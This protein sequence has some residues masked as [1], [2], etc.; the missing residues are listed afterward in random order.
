[1]TPVSEKARRAGVA[2][3]IGRSNV[4]KSTLLNALV[5]TKIAIITPKPQTTRMS[6]HGI[7]TR[8]QAQIIF[9]DTPGVLKKTRDALTKKMAE[10]IKDSLDG[11]DVLLYVVDPTRGIGEEQR[12]A[13]KWVMTEGVSKILV[14][15]KIDLTNLPYLQEY[16]ALKDQFDD[17]VEVSALQHTNIE[18]LVQKIIPLL[19][20]GEFFYPEYQLTNIPNRLW[21]AELI[22]EKLFLRLR[23]EL[24]YSTNVEVTALE[25]RENGV[26][27]I[28]ASILTTS[29]R[30]Q[31]MIIGKQGHVVKEIGRTARREMEVAT[32][33]KI[34]LDLDVR[35]DPHWMERLY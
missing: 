7:V 25:E 35:V 3:M 30:Y 10:S 9:V 13:L 6:I 4:G 1:L 15:N 31:R 19:P 17:L 8:D 21:M 18:V 23:Q 14:I 27:Y 26:L 11:V 16:R 20:E 24:P 33:R 32:N 22:R 12:Y 34:F 5:G 28:A 29:E 2:V